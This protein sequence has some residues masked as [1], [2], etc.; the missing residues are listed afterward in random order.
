MDPQVRASRSTFPFVVFFFAYAAFLLVELPQYGLTF[1]VPYEFS[2]ATAYVERFVS[3]R[4][5]PLQSP[6]DRR[7]PWHVLPWDTARNSLT[8]SLHASLPSMIAAL[9]GKLFFEWLGLLGAIDAFHLGLT[10]IWLG[11]LVCFY[12]RLRALH[13]GAVALLACIVLG[14]APRVVGDVHNNMK[15]VP[16]MAFTSLALLEVASAVIAA[17]PRRGAIATLAPTKNLSSYPA[18]CGMVAIQCS[19][20]K[21]SVS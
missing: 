8:L 20:R 10:L 11:F 6:P 9:S 18:S 17:R 19:I 14:L 15:D 4:T 16:A 5:D 2:R 7:P 12:L 3:G 21:C 13:D 1:D